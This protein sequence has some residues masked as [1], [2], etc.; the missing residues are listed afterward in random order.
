MLLVGC[1]S[2]KTKVTPQT[3]GITF[4]CD[5]TYYNETYECKGETNDKGEM[6][7]EFLSPEDINGL[8][9]EF[10][11]SGVTSSFK[12]TEYKSQRIVFEN[13]V[14]TFIYEVLSSENTDVFKE[15]DRLFTE[16][17]TD[18]FEYKL[19]LG[20]TGL[21]LKITTRPD[22]VEV[23]FREVKIIENTV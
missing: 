21:P 1:G 11:Q 18:T 17:V 10:T 4:S 3:K 20:G 23:V 13:S 12:E 16:G 5:V 15:N 2:A 7:I 19:H 8:K 9:F 22:A 14:A 6:S